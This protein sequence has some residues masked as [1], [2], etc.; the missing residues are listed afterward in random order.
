M[1]RIVLA[2]M[3]AYYLMTAAWSLLHLRSFMAV[4]GPKEERWLVKT[5]GALVGVSGLVMAVSALRRRPPPEVA[6][7]AGGQASALAAVD[8]WYVS[9]R[10]ISPVYLLDAVAELAGLAALVRWW[11]RA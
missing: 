11:P 7:L 10:R 6:L 4:T 5:V 2:L 8:A 9:G 1:A 3:G